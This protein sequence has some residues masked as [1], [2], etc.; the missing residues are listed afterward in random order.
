MRF[1]FCRL[2]II[3]NTT[4]NTKKI[5]HENIHIPSSV[6]LTI[7]DSVLFASNA[8]IIVQP[9]GHLIVN[10]GTLTNACSGEM[11]Q[12][13]IVEGNSSLNQSGSNQG[14]ITLQNGAIIENAVKAISTC[15]SPKSGGIISATDATFKNNQTA[16]EFNPYLS[17]LTIDISSFKK[18]NFVI[19]H[20]NLFSANDLI[21]NN[22]VKLDGV[23]G[24][25]FLGCQFDYNPFALIFVPTIGGISNTSAINSMNAG[26][27]VTDHC[28]GLLIDCNCLGGTLTRNTFSGFGEAIKSYTT[29]QQ[30]PITIDHALFSNNSYGITIQSTNNVI[31]TRSDFNVPTARMGILLN[32]CS[33]YKIEGNNFVSPNIT[34]DPNIG[35]GVVNSGTAENKI[36][37][38]TFSTFYTGILTSLVNGSTSSGLQFNCNTFDNNVTAI[39][40]TGDI[41]PHQ[42][43]TNA[44]ADNYF[45]NIIYGLSSTTNQQLTYIFSPA[46]NHTP[47][48][49]N[50]NILLYSSNVTANTCNQT[51]CGPFILDPWNPGGGWTLLSSGGKSTNFL[52][53]Y[54]QMKSEYNTLSFDF[55]S[56]DYGQVLSTMNSKNNIHSKEA[57]AKA[58][59]QQEAISVLSRRMADISDAAISEVLNDSILVLDNLK[60]WY[61]AVNTPIAKYSLVETHYQDGEY[62]LAD[63]ALQNIP[64]LFDFTNEEITEHNNYERIHAL[65]NQLQLTEKYWP[66]LTEEEIDELIAI[67]EANTGRSSSMAK[68]VLCFYFDICYENT[69]AID[70]PIKSKSEYAKSS[71]NV[72]LEETDNLLSIYPNPTSSSVE[73]ELSNLDINILQIEISDIF[74]KIIKTEKGS[75][76]H[77]K[78]NLSDL[79]NGIYLFRIYLSNGEVVVRK[80]VKN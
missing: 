64:Y 13:I 28:S 58:K 4:W 54:N 26:F 33:G 35:I 72:L 49:D 76:S 75:T 62:A 46:S 79:N 43:A 37:R 2:I 15:V 44:G 25:S 63:A 31:I 40:V 22:H 5:I 29:G 7:K 16:I 73:I 69:I 80:V 20:E 68:G 60:L 39:R 19:D 9:G 38:N 52:T 42:G 24:V 71:G 14:R 36:Y 53:Q 1:L 65:K 74:G 61:D 11:W 18:C 23:R 67:A 6:T 70:M 34:L 66:N 10:G 55:Q 30:Y 32:D 50:S 59:A 8:Q 56:K 21:F 57:I 47:A 48:I 41:R 12:G 27:Q 45:K 77:A 3:E 17:P 51:V 78:V